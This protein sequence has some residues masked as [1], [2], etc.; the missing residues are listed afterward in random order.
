[1]DAAWQWA[2]WSYNDEPV[3]ISNKCVPSSDR[4]Q[5]RPDQRRHDSLSQTTTSSSILHIIARADSYQP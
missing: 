1:M 4:S 5:L 2:V 3:H